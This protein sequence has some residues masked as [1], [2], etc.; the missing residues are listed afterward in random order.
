MLSHY[1]TQTIFNDGAARL[2]ESDAGRPIF[3]SPLPVP[4][5]S[6][7][8]P[9]MKILDAIA[10]SLGSLCPLS[11]A[12]LAGEREVLWQRYISGDELYEELHRYDAEMVRLANEAQDREHP[13]GSEPRHR[14]HGW[15]WSPPERETALRR[16]ER[17]EHRASTPAL[18]PK[19]R[20]GAAQLLS[21]AARNYAFIDSDHR[22]RWNPI[23]NY[24]SRSRSNC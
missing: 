5:T 22:P 6:C 3:R 15:Y 2:A 24:S 17:I 13:D 1:A 10:R 14:E 16:S 21:D 23:R 20:P 8:H 11:D 4:P 19:S 9:C 18:K 12:E 7:Q